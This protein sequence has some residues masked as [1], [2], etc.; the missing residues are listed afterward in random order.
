MQRTVPL[1]ALLALLLAAYAVFMGP[2]DNAAAPTKTE[3]TAERVLR[4]GVLRCGYIIFP[5]AM[6]KDLE[7]GTL[8][9]FYHDIVMELGRRLSLKVEWTEEPPLDQAL[10]GITHGRYDT[11]CF[12]VYANS[13]RAREVMF[14]APLV[15]ASVYMTVAAD[16]QTLTG[17]L[18]Q[19][20]DPRFRMATLDGEITSILATQVFPRAVNH[21]VPQ[22]QGFSFVMKDLAEGKA[23]FTIADPKSIEDFNKNNTKK[24]KLIGP[25]A[26]TNAIAF[27][28]PHDP[29]F[30]NMIDVTLNELILDGFVAR[31]IDKY[32]YHS[33]VVLPLP[34]F[35]ERTP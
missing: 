27:P 35:K 33:S 34:P 6:I 13:N 14:S 21:A 29:R 3:T 7:T 4:T 19:A 25:P 5:P 31:M 28:L 12:P 17:D 9:G 22:G 1:I 23:D 18:A 16:N 15:Y 20:N 2:N 10:A 8:S 30:K 32:D 11:F 26:V 24:L